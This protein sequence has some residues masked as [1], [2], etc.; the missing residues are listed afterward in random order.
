MEGATT[1]GGIMKW[2]LSLLTLILVCLFFIVDLNVK[3]EEFSNYSSVIN[4]M[5]NPNASF[6]D[7]IKIKLKQWTSGP[8]AIIQFYT[9]QKPNQVEE[10]RN[11][12][13]NPPVDIDG[14]QVEVTSALEGINVQVTSKATSVKNE[15][16]RGLISMDADLQLP[17]AE[18]MRF[19]SNEPILY[20][21]Q[22]RDYPFIIE[23]SQKCENTPVDVS[24]INMDEF[25]YKNHP[26]LLMVIKSA[27]HLQKRR[28]AIRVT[29]GDE[30][31]AQDQEGIILKRVFLL[32]AC[33]TP[34]LQRQVGM[35]NDM[36]H[37]LLQWDFYDSFRNL[38]L[39]D[40]LFMQWYSSKC[41]NIPFIF[42]GDD[43]VFVN[44]RELIRYLK[45]YPT[46]KRNDMFVGSVLDGSPRIL[47]ARS[48]YYVSYN[49]YPGKLYPAYVSGGGFVMSGNMTVRMFQ[50]SLKERIIPIDDAFLGIL[51]KR[52]KVRPKNDK[53]FKSWGMAKRD[54]CRLSKVFTF[55]RMTAQEIVT[56]WKS[57]NA[58]DL[59]SCERDS[60]DVFRTQMR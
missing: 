27:C 39:K 51:L 37:D 3:S 38:T 2:K 26:F 24:Q 18:P 10:E 48:K 29:W 8:H 1:S 25:D 34:E 14:S 15:S 31:W 35:E 9:A 57:L 6:Q 46:E 53:R 12:D 13:D 36:Y 23:N 40:C 5:K 44:P 33:R 54:I 22:Q 17:E 43:D 60:D 4:Y 20:Y 59:T 21:S 19:D 16:L 58:L 11:K 41:R 45:Q 28:E 47:D 56:N 50:A 30:T 49:L 32:G 52:I 7:E 42:K 55:H